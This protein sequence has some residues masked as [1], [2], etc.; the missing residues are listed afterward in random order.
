MR[1]VNSEKGAMLPEIMSGSQS[2][3]SYRPFHRFLFRENCL[4]ATG[5]PKG[6]YF[7]SGKLVMERLSGLGVPSLA[8]GHEDP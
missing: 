3:R 1:E 8:A 6:R 2:G 7:L 5:W 4:S